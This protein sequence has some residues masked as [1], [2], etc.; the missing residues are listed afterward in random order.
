[1]Q[2]LRDFQGLLKDQCIDGWIIVP[3]WSPIN[4][5]WGLSC[6][7]SCSSSLN[8]TWND[9]VTCTLKSIN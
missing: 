8:N 5:S 9:T 2:N 1:L 4:I 6:G 3:Q 7:A